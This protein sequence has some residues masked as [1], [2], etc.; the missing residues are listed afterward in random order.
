VQ[1]LLKLHSAHPLERD[2][3]RNSS[4]GISAVVQIVAIVNISD[5]DVIVVIPVISPIFR[6]WVKSTDPITVILKAGISANNQEGKPGDAEPMV[7]TKVS[8]ESVIRNA[9]AAVAAT[10]L[11]GAVV[12][13]PAS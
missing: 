11:P 4:A 12:G 7:L 6:P 2:T 8:T 1:P 13:I 3:D 9:V 10:L 5:I